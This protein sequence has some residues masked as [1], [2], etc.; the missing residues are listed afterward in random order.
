MSVLDFYEDSAVYKN[1][2]GLIGGSI[3]RLLTP[4]FGIAGT[5]LI[6]VALF[7]VS[8]VLFAGKS[9]FVSILR[10]LQ[11]WTLAAAKRYREHKALM[12]DARRQRRM[13]EEAVRLDNGGNEELTDGLDDFD[14]FEDIDDIDDMKAIQEPMEAKRPKR[15]RKKGSGEAML[16]PERCV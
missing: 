9:V 13:E 11:Q 15:R 10:K 2:G 3:C 7:A 8:V 5:Y 1:G 16:E 14:D 6:I 4:L 12:D